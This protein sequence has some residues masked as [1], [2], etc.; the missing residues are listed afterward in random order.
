M[1]LPGFQEVPRSVTCLCPGDRAE[2]LR[3][4]DMLRSLCDHL[5]CEAA[6]RDPGSEGGTGARSSLEGPVLAAT[7]RAD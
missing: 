5:C 7:V 3:H 4:A 1:H 2:A 6:V